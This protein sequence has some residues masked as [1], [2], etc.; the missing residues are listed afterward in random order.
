MFA[1]DVLCFRSNAKITSCFLLIVLYII[2]N[3]LIPNNEAV[4][5]L[6]HRLRQSIKEINSKIAREDQG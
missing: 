4:K 3:G 1:F 2:I 5:C 6:T